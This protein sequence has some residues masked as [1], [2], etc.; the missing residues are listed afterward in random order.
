MSEWRTEGESLVRDYKVA[1]FA[2]ALKFVNAVG[3]LAEEADHH[4][5]I[6]IHGYN[7][8]RLTLST[9]DAGKVTDKDH[10]LAA[11]IDALGNG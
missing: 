4:P 5:D 1:D 9:H 7:N 2:A 6:L 3:E 8:V 10:A 11:R